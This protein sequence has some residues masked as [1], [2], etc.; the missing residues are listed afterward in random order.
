MDYRELPRIIF[1]PDI[2]KST[3]DVILY[4]TDDLCVSPGLNDPGLIDIAE[5]K[6]NKICHTMLIIKG[7]LFMEKLLLNVLQA[8]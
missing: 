6:K 8:V 4:T 1:H 3:L 5:R 7:Q 2:F